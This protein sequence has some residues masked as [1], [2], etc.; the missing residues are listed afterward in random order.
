MTDEA[1]FVNKVMWLVHYHMQVLYVIKDLPFQDISGMR[2]RVSIYDVALLGYCDRL[3]RTGA[4]TDVERNN[5]SVFLEKCNERI[6]APWL[7]QE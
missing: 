3:G 4:N 5:V 1:D 7:R 2:E 6:N